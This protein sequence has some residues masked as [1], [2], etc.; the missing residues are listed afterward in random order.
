MEIDIFFVV[1]LPLTKPKENENKKFFKRLEYIIL[2]ILQ[3]G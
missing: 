3:D 2:E 1:F